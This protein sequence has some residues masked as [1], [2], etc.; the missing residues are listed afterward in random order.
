MAFR[1]RRGG[2]HSQANLLR[3]RPNSLSLG[4]VAGFLRV[5]LPYPSGPDSVL[6]VRLTLLAPGRES[7]R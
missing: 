5:V 6:S 2:V 7:W 1:R 4:P 3:G